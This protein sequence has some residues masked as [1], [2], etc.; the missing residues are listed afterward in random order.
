MPTFRHAKGTRVFCDGYDLSRALKNVSV[1]RQNAPAESTGFTCAAKEFISGIPEVSVSADG[2][3]A[4]DNATTLDINNCQEAV[5]ALDGPAALCIG[6]DGG[7]TAGKLVVA[8]QALQ[9]DITIQSP[10]TDI[11]STTAAF[12]GTDALFNGYSLRDPDSVLSLTG[13]ASAGTGQDYNALCDDLTPTPIMTL[14]GICVLNVIGN[15]VGSTT[16][17]KIQHS[18]A[19]G[20]AYV[21][22]ATFTIPANTRAG[23]TSLITPQTVNRWIRYNITATGTGDLKFIAAFVPR[24]PSST[25]S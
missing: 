19:I 9:T 23:Y 25:V 15:S 11:V 14:G 7:V 16:T 18:T 22:L 13:A 6:F 5:L 12:K 20:G 4:Y 24:T 8:G 3:F 17:M 2:M 1:Q 21:D 10:A